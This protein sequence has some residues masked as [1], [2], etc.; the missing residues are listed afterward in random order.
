MKKNIFLLML[1]CAG[2]LRAQGTDPTPGA[3]HYTTPTPVVIQKWSMS[4]IPWDNW[5]KSNPYNITVTDKTDY[6][7]FMWNA[8]DFKAAFEVKDK[9][10]R[11]SQS[12]LQ[13]VLRLYPPDAKAD[14]VKVDVVYAP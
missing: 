7:H 8:W 14:L 10:P 12:V 1:F 6:V 11:L 5:F 4:A 13:L 9:K 2:T 3:S